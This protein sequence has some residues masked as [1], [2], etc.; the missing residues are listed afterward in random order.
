MVNMN[1]AAFAAMA[2]ATKQ[3]LAEHHSM[4]ALCIMAESLVPSIRTITTELL[5]SASTSNEEV[6]PEDIQ[7]YRHLSGLFH[8]IVYQFFHIENKDEIDMR[9]LKAY[10]DIENSINTLIKGLEGIKESGKL[11]FFNSAQNLRELSDSYNT[12]LNAMQDDLKKGSPLEF[13]EV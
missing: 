11:G 1:T 10:A 9:M 6:T 12:A 7:D 8:I 13:K 3:A 4:N 2:E 5:I